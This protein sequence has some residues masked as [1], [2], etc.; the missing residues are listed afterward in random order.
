MV[1]VI[2]CTLAGL[3][4]TIATPRPPDPIYAGRRVSAWF[5]DLCATGFGTAQQARR[6]AA[7][8]AAFTNMAPDAVPFLADQLLYDRSG[9]RM[10]LTFYTLRYTL[11]EHLVTN[12]LWPEDRRCYAAAALRRMGPQAEAAIPALLEAWAHDGQNMRVASV[13]ALESIMRG[14]YTDWLSPFEHEMLESSVIA[15]AARRYPAVAKELGIS[16]EAMEYGGHCDSPAPRAETQT[17]ANAVVAPEGPYPPTGPVM[18]SG[19]R[20]LRPADWAEGG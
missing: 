14:H 7:S 17:L 3:L 6:H 16:P 13:W 4:F 10:K 12:I 2:A 1:G 15:E 9:I 11:N 8:Y 20:S 19:P 5:D 18:Q